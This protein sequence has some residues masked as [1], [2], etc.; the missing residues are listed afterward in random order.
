MTQL[1][2]GG[3]A[4]A[5][6]NV[7]IRDLFP[8]LERWS[9]KSTTR[10]QPLLSTASIGSRDHRRASRVGARVGHM[11]SLKGTGVAL[12]V[13]P[14]A[15]LLAWLRVHMVAIDGDT[16]LFEATALEDRTVVIAAS[17]SVVLGTRL[18]AVV[19]AFDA[20]AV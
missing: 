18:L 20:P 13:D 7:T 8:H 19:P 11:L 4:P 1:D 15:E 12:C 17:H 6:A 16:I 3:E 14:S 2:N 5:F 10:T 9:M